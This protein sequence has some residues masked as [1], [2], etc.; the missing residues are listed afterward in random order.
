MKL[1]ISFLALL[2]A[3]LASTTA[4][5]TLPKSVD[6]F[7]DPRG[8]VPVRV[9]LADQPVLSADYQVIL[10][11][12]T[13]ASRVTLTGVPLLDL[14]RT[15]G[16]SIEGVYFVE[17]RFGTTNGS[18]IALIPLNQDSTSRPPMI[19]SSGRVPNRGVFPTPA[20][21]PGQPDLSRPLN[22]STFMPFSPKGTR[23]ALVPGA[24]GARILSVK[25]FAKKRKSGEYILRA[26]CRSCDS[27]RPRSYSWI[28][29]DAT[30]NPVNLGAGRSIETQD[31]TH[32]A[33]IHAVSV[34]IRESG[35]GSTGVGQFSYLSRAKKK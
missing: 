12:S 3:L 6:V 7:Q 19:L 20:V 32:G 13:K 16:A 35:T 5:A 4:R 17:I 29:Y 15:V 34:V 14:L 1:R 2:I 9:I 21:I 11:G 28:G 8:Q 10:R 26:S 23:L 22:E 27:R 18:P 31:A 30:G 25:V 33:T 24:T